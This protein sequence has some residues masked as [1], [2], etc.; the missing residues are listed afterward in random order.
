[1]AGSHRATRPGELPGAAAFH[2]DGTRLATAGR[3]RAV[4]LWDLARGEEVA[5]LQ[6][7]TSYVWTLAFSP[8]GMTLASGSGDFRVRL[9]D[10]VPIKERYQARRE[11]EAL[12]PQAERLVEA[13]WRQ[14]TAPAAVVDALRADPALGES[15]RHAALR[16]VLRRGIPAET[17]PG[18]PP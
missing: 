6:R 12:R 10:T 5:R 16:A 9:W 3:D 8:D 15:L 13:L 7:H 17:A 1:M 18:I 2:P 4:C 11:A 14:N